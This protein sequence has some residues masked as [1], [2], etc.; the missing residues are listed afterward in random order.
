[1][2][3]CVGYMH[4]HVYTSAHSVC[5]CVCVCVSVHECVC[6]VCVCVCVSV[7][8]CVVCAPTSCWTTLVMTASLQN[9]SSSGLL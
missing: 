6:G 8:V 5:V 3:M 4:V 7:H 2:N 9:V 1:M